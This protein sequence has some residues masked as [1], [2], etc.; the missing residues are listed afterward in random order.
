MLTIIQNLQTCYD[1]HSFLKFT[2]KVIDN[3]LIIRDGPRFH[4]FQ[5]DLCS[6]KDFW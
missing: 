4:H 6:C 1:C 2:F 3:H 5:S